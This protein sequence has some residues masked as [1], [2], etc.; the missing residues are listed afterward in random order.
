MSTLRQIR[1][2]TNLRGRCY[3][4]PRPLPPNFTQLARDAERLLEA[5]PGHP[6]VP[7]ALRANAA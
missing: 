4:A 2:S 7:E 3:P 1:T 5:L 6:V